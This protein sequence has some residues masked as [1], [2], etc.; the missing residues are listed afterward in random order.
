MA[1]LLRHRPGVGTS[2]HDA[3]RFCL[4]KH[5]HTLGQER[6]CTSLENHGSISAGSP[7]YVSRPCGRCTFDENVQTPAEQAPKVLPGKPELHLQQAAA[8]LGDYRGRYSAG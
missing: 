1:C 6:R 5:R 8:S 7:A 3:S 4:S 2:E